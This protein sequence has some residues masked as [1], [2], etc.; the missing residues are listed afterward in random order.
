MA[1]GE[2]LELDVERLVNGPGAMARG[3]DGR[4]V[5][6]DEGFPGERVRAVVESERRGYRRARVVRALDPPS[7]RRRPPRCGV[8]AL[9]GGCPWQ[10]LEYDAQVRAKQQVVVDEITHGAGAAPDEVRA[11]VTGPEW[12]SRHRVR[13]G[14]KHLREGPPAV[15]YRG[16][17]AHEVVPIDD[18]VI[19]R[20]ELVAALPLARAVAAELRSAREIEISVDDERRIFLRVVC[21]SGRAPDAE[22]LHGGLVTKAA[23]IDLDGAEYAGLRL[24]AARGSPSWSASAGLT[25]QAIRVAPDLVLDVP[26]GAFTQVNADLNPALV[27]A[28][29]T[30]VSDAS[31]DQV[32]DLY[33]GAGNFSL[34]L[35]RAGCAVVGVDTD[36]RAIAAA[37][38]S[39][40]THALTDRA[41][42]EVGAAESERL[43]PL[44]SRVAPD[45]VVLDP[46]R[47]GA[48][49]ALPALIAARPTTIVY[50]SCDVATFAR[51]ARKI[52]EAG[53]GFSSLQLL[54]LTPQSHRAE[55][56][57]VFRLTWERSGPYRD[58]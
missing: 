53:W 18:C 19:A 32:L 2:E 12:G 11:P 56:L 7:P 37:R 16:R 58:G 50:V 20:P 28:V 21:G 54:D 35:A 47:A 26:V 34:P 1:Q 52:V 45:V 43:A 46:P 15:G 9:C 38:A 44:L 27:G 49:A 33:C 41:R 57:G 29:V 42:F 48:A 39:A 40:V 17:G 30:A 10:G 14:V 3:P 24:E 31:A 22:S 8:T 55:V 13:L 36:E 4:V 25:T 51:D 5:F 23:A 6:V